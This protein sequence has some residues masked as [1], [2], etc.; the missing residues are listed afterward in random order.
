MNRNP[1]ASLG[2]SATVVNDKIYFAGA[3]GNWFAWD[4]GGDYSSTINIFDV[5]TGNWSTSFL[6]EAKGAM[7]G[8]GTGNKNIWAGGLNSAFGQSTFLPLNTVEIKD[9]VTGVSTFDCLFQPNSGFSV[10]QKGSK[11][12]FFTAHTTQA[13][14]LIPGIAT[15]KFDI[16]DIFSGTWSIGVL[17]VDI[18][19]ASI[20]S[21][22][23]TIY[24]AGGY[25]NGF[26]SSQVWKLEF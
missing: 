14:W 8:I 2:I 11:I 10:V 18:Y 15:N 20:I 24:V 21:V 13:G 17:P 9:I 7:G 16:Y 3:A 12:V 5:N 25:V 1:S 6:R 23:N 22:N 26:L 4:F 19:D